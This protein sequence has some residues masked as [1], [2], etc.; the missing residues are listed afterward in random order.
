MG[1][2]N[3]VRFL[4]KEGSQK[5]FEDIFDTFAVNDG[6]NAGYLIKT[7]YSEYVY[8][9]IWDS[10]EALAASRDKMISDLVK[11]EVFLR[12]LQLDL[13]ILDQVILSGVGKCVY[14]AI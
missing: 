8:V 3:V 9:G 5:D 1:F 2:S 13:Q 4:V 12:R 6:E 14:T 11:C 10:E 7:G